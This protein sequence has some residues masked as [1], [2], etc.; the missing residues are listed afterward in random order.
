MGKLWNALVF[1]CATLATLVLILELFF[2]KV[3]FC[4]CM[5]LVVCGMQLIFMVIEKVKRR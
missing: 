5:L 2:R 1:L 3:T 4:H